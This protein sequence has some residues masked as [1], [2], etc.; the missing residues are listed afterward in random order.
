MCSA[1]AM[2]KR[3]LFPMRPPGDERTRPSAPFIS[4]TMTPSRRPSLNSTRSNIF[5]ISLVLAVGRGGGALGF[6]MVYSGKRVGQLVR[7]YSV[8]ERRQLRFP[9][10]SPGQDE[11][12]QV[13]DEFSELA[14]RLQKPKSCA[15]I[16]LNASHELK[17]PL[18]STSCCP[19]PFCRPGTSQRV[20]ERVPH[21]YQRGNRPS[22][23][24]TERLLQLTKKLDYVSS[25]RCR[26]CDLNGLV[27]KITDLLKEKRRPCSGGAGK[28]VGRGSVG[29]V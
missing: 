24:I 5:R 3:P 11:L 19:I 14:D 1:A 21:R 6:L 10:P 23:R 2:G 8:H 18:A 7:G 20:G 17:T 25:I 16:C 28:S 12:S 9:H 15:G 29:V 4:M 22:D 27:K 13:A 26:S